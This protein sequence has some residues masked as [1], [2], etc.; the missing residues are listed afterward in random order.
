M[1]EGRVLALGPTAELRKRAGGEVRVVDA[2]RR[3]V[4]SSKPGGRINQGDQADLVLIDD[5]VSLVPLP[6]LDEQSI[7]LE[8]SAGRVVRDRDSSPT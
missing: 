5:L 1:R 8:L 3:M 7:M 4:V 2:G 6:E